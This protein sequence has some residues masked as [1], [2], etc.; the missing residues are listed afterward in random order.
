MKLKANDYASSHLIKIIREWTEMS[1]QDFAQ[2]I[3]LTRSAIA[4]YEG[5][6]RNF[7][8]ATF[9]KICREHNIDVILEKKK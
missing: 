1:Q 8:F 2:S 5:D 4:K 6:E 7:S 9:M 3:G